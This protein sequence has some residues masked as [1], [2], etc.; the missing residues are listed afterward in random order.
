MGWVTEPFLFNCP[1]ASVHSVLKKPQAC[2]WGGKGESLD[3][4]P[5]ESRACLQKK[6]EDCTAMN[7]SSKLPRPR[8]K[9]DPSN[10]DMS[11]AAIETAQI[12]DKLKKRRL[13]ESILASNK[14]KMD[15]ISMI[16]GQRSCYSQWCKAVEDIPSWSLH[17]FSI[18]S[19]L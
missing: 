1:T 15:V 10:L 6:K 2:L 8:P 16:S 18:L 5:L 17:G 19:F 12:K 14:S 7:D 11:S 4:S 3:I 9:Q 13:S